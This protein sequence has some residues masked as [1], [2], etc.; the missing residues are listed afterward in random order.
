M[1]VKYF[2][3]CIDTSIIE[4]KSNQEST[5]SCDLEITEVSSN[6]LKSEKIECIPNMKRKKKKTL[7]LLD[8]E[9]EL[10]VKRIQRIIDEEQKLANIK[11]KHEETTAKM[12]KEHL[13]EI[14]YMQMQH[15]KEINK[16]EI[17]ISKAKLRSMECQSIAKENIDP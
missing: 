17:Q 4:E 7:E 12:K 2:F 14:N 3:Y 9:E 6:I 13:K 5:I 16:I 8:M 1:I 10:R 11:L 15:L